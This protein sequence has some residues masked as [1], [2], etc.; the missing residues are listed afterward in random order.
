MPFDSPDPLPDSDIETIESWIRALE[1][2]A[3]LG[4]VASQTDEFGL[5]GVGEPHIHVRDVHA[6]ILN[7][8]GLQDERLTYLHDGRFRKLTDIGGRL[9]TE[10]IL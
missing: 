5:R 3:Q 8:L 6:T 10:I 2:D 7:L 1:P 9:L 4:N